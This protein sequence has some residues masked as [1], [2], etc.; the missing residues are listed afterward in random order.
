MKRKPFLTTIL[1]VVLSITL[2][3]IAC[4]QIPFLGPKR[5]KGGSMFGIVIGPSGINQ[6]GVRHSP[7]EGATVEARGPK[8]NFNTMTDAQGG[9]KFV[10]IAAGNYT[11]SVN[12]PGYGP[13]VKQISI[14]DADV[15]NMGHITLI[16]GGGLTIPQGV[17]VPD[18]CYVAFARIEVD[19][20]ASKTSLWRK[21]A[22]MHGADPFA[23][24]GNKPQ[25]YTVHMNPYDKGHQVSSFEN[26]LMTIDP[27]NTNKVDYIKLEGRPTW[28][29][30][31]VAGTKL[32]VADDGNR[33]SVYDVLHNNIHIGGVSLQSAATDLKLSP[34]GKWLFISNADG[35]TIVDTK[36]HVPVNHIEMPTMSNG[37]PG[38]PMAITC[39]P[40]GTKLYVALAAMDS[41]EVVC[42]DAYTKQPIGRAMVGASPTGIAITPDGRRLFVADHNSADVAVLSASPLSLITRTSVGVSPARLIVSPDGSKVYVTCKGSGTVAILSAM[43]GGNIGSVH[44]GKEPM[45]IAITGDGSRVYVANHADGTVSIIDANAGV[46]LKRTRPQPHSRPFG[47]AVK[48]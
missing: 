11:I 26:S 43:T 23:L 30:F 6:P 1:I 9:F 37:Q 4:A 8:G 40:D 16:P 35:V 21:G 22:I 34:D 25:D 46:E 38:F 44:V 14:K 24:D 12:K 39:S 10:M 27:Q 29:C 20:S 42:V 33:V 15:K 32:Y 17:V 48:P 47:I 31:N 45:G 41:G 13:F 3:A 19:K 2:F 18:T 36:T 5:A 7:I 28:L